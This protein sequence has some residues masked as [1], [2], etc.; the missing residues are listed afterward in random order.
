MGQFFEPLYINGDPTDYSNTH[1]PD[2]KTHNNTTHITCLATDNGTKAKVLAETFF[3]PPPPTPSIL[4]SVYPNPLLAR[5]TFTRA[6]IRNP[7]KNLKL[8]KAPGLDRIKNLVLKEC[9][10]PLIDNLYHIYR[11]ILKLNI[12]PTCWLMSLMV[13]LRKPGK[14]AYW[15][16][17]LLDT[18][19]KL[20]S[21]LIASDLS[22]I[23]EKHQ[24]LL[25][26]QFGGR[27]GC[28]TTDAIHLVTHQI[29][30]T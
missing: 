17:G 12:Y 28:C 11:A 23:T 10:E 26:T 29:K 20:F 25:P 22:H 18:M 14:L 13:V 4:I 1:I 21:A 27:P 24:L 15:P 7:I 16:I 2:L 9:V 30:N 3:P 8:N 5:G 6:D 19:G